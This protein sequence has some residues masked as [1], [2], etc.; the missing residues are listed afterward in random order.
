MVDADY[1]ITIIK[2]VAESN[3]RKKCLKEGV[4]GGVNVPVFKDL[5]S[6]QPCCDHVVVPRC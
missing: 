1:K 5:A 2:G 4:L 3:K 6:K